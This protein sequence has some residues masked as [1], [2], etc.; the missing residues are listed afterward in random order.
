V[1]Q[2]FL[3]VADFHMN[4]Q[5]AV[6]WPRFHHQWK[7]DKLF[8]EKGVSPDTIA[9]LKAMGHD[10]ESSEAT[11]VVVARVEA[12]LLDN[13]WLQGGADGRSSGKAAGY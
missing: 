9:L 8:V 12:I 4:V 2:V 7:P 11:A 13:G 10:V 1:L 6:D 5:E 3:N